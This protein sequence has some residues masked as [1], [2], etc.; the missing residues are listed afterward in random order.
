M[1]SRSRQNLARWFTLS[2]GSVFL[3]FVALFYLREAHDR[4]RFFDRTL[5][6]ISEIIAANVEEI[7][8]QN[9]RQIDLENVPILGSDAIRLDKEVLFARWYN[10]E[11]QLLQFIGPIPQTTLNSKLGFETI[12]GEGSD[13]YSGK[14]RQLTL[15]VYQ[16]GKLLGYLQIAASLAPVEIPLQQLQIFLVIV[17][18][19]MLLTIALIGWF[20]GGA[21]MQPIRQSYQQLQQF[22]A[23]AAHELRAPL[24]GIVS[25][26]QVGLMEPIDPQEQTSR[27]QTIAKVAE[28]MGVL[29]GHLLFLARNEGKLPPEALRSTDLVNLLQPIVEEYRQQTATKNLTFT[30]NLPDRPLILKVEPDLIRQA[31]INLLSNACRYTLS[32]GKIELT[33]ISQPR[34]VIIQVKDTGI[35]IGEEDLQRIFDRFYRV[36]KVRTYQ[37]GGFGLGLAITHQIIAAHNG[38]ISVKSTLGKGSTFEIRLPISH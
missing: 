1:F 5:F 17:V 38:Q 37:T 11:K 18:P 35:G 14:L 23:D 34:W 32:G 4:L 33:I 12:Y 10:P 13:N 28:S 24:A 7:V 20:L 6:N 16:E 9:Q 29:L 27:L 36:D 25:N 31:I 21:A 26:A 2:M 8:Y 3:V 30:A 19:C 15:P 22:T